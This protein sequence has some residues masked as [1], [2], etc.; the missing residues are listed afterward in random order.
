[1]STN[2]ANRPLDEAVSFQQGFPTTSITI[3][4]TDPVVQ[5]T[6]LT[7]DNLP[8]LQDATPILGNIIELSHLTN[9]ITTELDA[10]DLSKSVLVDDNIDL[11]NTSEQTEVLIEK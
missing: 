8:N 5:P 4:H 3:D 2:K 6:E 11:T 7:G 10:S 9:D 1:M